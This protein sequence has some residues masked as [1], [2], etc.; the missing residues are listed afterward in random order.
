MKK[1]L[2]SIL[3]LLLPL[4]LVEAQE[5]YAV[6]SE[7]NTVLTFYYD[8]EK[9]SRNGMSVGPFN[10]AESERGWFEQRQQITS[11]VFDDSFAGCTNITSTANWFEGFSSMTSIEG[12]DNLNTGEVT[13]MSC[14]FR[15]CSKL[16]N[17]NVT[18]FKTGKVTNMSD[19]FSGCKALTTLD[20]RNFNMENVVNMAYMFSSC[21]SLISLYASDLNT[22]NVANMEALFF[23]CSSLTH[24]DVTHL[25]TDNV[26]NTVCMFAGS[27]SLTDLDLSS[28]QTKKFYKTDS[29]F[30]YCTKLKTIYVSEGWDMDNVASSSAMFKDCINLVGGDGTAFNSFYTDKTKA[31]AGSGGY[32]TLKE[33][34]ETGQ[35]SEP[36][37]ENQTEPYALFNNNVLTF[38]YD[39]QKSSRKGMDIGPFARADERGW[40]SQ[41]NNIKTVVFDETFADC[42][43]ITSTR[44]WFASF[45][46]LT[47]IVGI[48]NLCTDNVT[49]MDAMFADCWHLTSLDVSKFNTA[50]VTSMYGMFSGCRAL[51]SIDVSNFNTANVTNMYQMFAECYGLTTLDISRFNTEKV[52]NMSGMFFNCH[53]LPSLDLRN[54]DMGNVT[55]MSLMFY[56]C[57]SLV[58]IKFGSFN[59]DNVTNMQGMFKGCVS[60]TSIDLSS[61]NTSN[62]IT[63]AQMFDM[64]DMK[65][66]SALKTIYVSEKWTMTN[67]IN[68]VNMFLGCIN[69]IGGD[70]TTY[71]YYKDKTKAYAGAGG[72]LT[73]M[74]QGTEP[75]DK[76]TGWYTLIDKVL[77]LN[78]SSTGE[79]MILR[80]DGYLEWNNK[81]DGDL[82]IKVY[83][84]PDDSYNL[85]FDDYPNNYQKITS[86]DGN[87][88]KLLAENGITRTFTIAESVPVTDLKDGDTFTA[89]TIE[90]VTMTFQVIS[91]KDKTCQVGIGSQIAIAKSVSG[92]VTIPSEAKG[93]QV[94]KIANRAFKEITG[95]TQVVIPNTVTDIGTTEFQ[96]AM[97]PFHCCTGITS[98][99]IPSSVT[100]I[101]RGAF[102]GTMMTTLT[103]PESVTVIGSN[104]FDG[105]ANLKS[106]ELSPNIH[107]IQME[108]FRNCK[109]LE[110]IEI[111]AGVTTIG[112]H[113]FQNC[114]SLATVTSHIEPPFAISADA[115]TR[116]DA[117]LYVPTGTVELYEN[118]SGWKRFF[119]TIKE[120]GA[121]EFS[122]TTS[123]GLTYT[124][125][126]GQTAVAVKAAKTDL[127]GDIII[128]EVVMNAG[129]AY[130]V[131]EISFKAFEGCSSIEKITLPKSLKKIGGSA[132][133]GCTSL[134]AFDVTEGTGSLSVV[135]GV[136]YA[137]NGATLVAYPAAKSGEFEIP[138]SVTSLND[139]AFAYARLTSLTV[140]SEEPLRVDKQTFEGIDFENCVLNVPLG[141]AA[142][143]RSAEGWSQFKHISGETEL[144]IDGATYAVYED[145]NVIY[146]VADKTAIS[147][148]YV[149]PS[150]INVDGVNMTVKEIAPNA[151][152]D[153]TGLISVTIP[154]S[155][156]AIG[157]SAFKGCI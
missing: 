44:S 135:D 52:T 104:A 69:L 14:M 41:R 141:S 9:E 145:G 138:A 154:K 33:E 7:N 23:Y 73:L 128:A 99:D 94:V 19:M 103:I 3:M 1:V 34:A 144:T 64:S 105:C 75:D 22:A 92:V 95:L 106:I 119:S 111:P 82:T 32:L 57:S 40:E 114:T 156:E 77:T 140:N 62:V 53:S 89:T 113:A 24:L 72:Y 49:N 61:F 143:Y 85:R 126:K 97:G 4:L 142:K 118:T 68:S 27:S 63:T 122:F 98:F 107:A 10:G 18:G 20:I 101:G 35:P 96:S 11:V 13:D 136:L 84:D 125:T 8:N 83:V 81:G 130:S 6:L 67:V 108:T 80:S 37:V 51:T 87:T 42:K 47:S 121:D 148:D 74:E 5:P 110:S 88:V 17:L 139:G 157:A 134:S 50:N 152:E 100:T 86:M 2:L 146:T 91:A 36:D 151:F 116:Y 29:M 71:G 30:E 124:G 15:Y 58:D 109:S 59:I 102:T 120:I 155:I 76:D 26:T 147:G 131:T 31:Y 56:I 123:K 132:F 78:G 79:Y 48:E 28:F 46:N 70:G 129:T 25:K 39:N 45:N 133:F 150:V 66:P 55:D 60:L 43:S 21:S 54:F 127:A 16:P 90:G 153:C 93:Y 115:F 112:Y 117:T 38:Y 65:L 137:D 12:I 149:I